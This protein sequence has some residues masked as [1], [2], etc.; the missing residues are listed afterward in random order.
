MKRALSFG[1]AISLLFA[2]FGQLVEAYSINTAQEYLEAHNDSPW[3]VMALA[4]LGAT[5]VRNDGLK[6][7]AGTTAIEY[8]APILAI[9]AMGENPR[10]FGATDY[11]AALKSY[12]HDSQLGD[13]TTLND[14]IFGILALVASDVPV[15]DAAI[16]DSKNILFTTQGLDGGWSFAIA[17]SSD[18]NMTASAILAL[19]AAEVPPTDAHILNA[20]NY[21]KSAQNDD[22]GFPY[23][24]SSSF[25]TNSDASS[26]AW[27]LWALNALGAS[28]EAWTKSGHTPEDYLT[29]TQT[30]SGY[31]EYQKGSG[32]DSFSPITTS[33]AVIALSGKKLPLKILPPSTEQQFDFRIEGSSG[34]ICS[35]TT[36]GPT[37]LDIIE[38]GS[39][40]CGYTY[41]I[42]DTSFGLYL[43]QISTDTAA[44]TK[45]WIY[46]VNNAAPSV[47]AADYT[48]KVDDHVLWFYGEYT[49]V[50]TRL[51]LTDSEAASG[52]SITVTVDS[53]ANNTWTALAN[54]TVHFGT[55]T[56]MT[57]ADGQ[58]VIHPAD[59]YYKIFAA[60]PGFVRTNTQL[61]KMGQPPSSSV[62]LNATIGQVLGDTAPLPTST[63]IAFTIEP[64]TLNFGTLTPGSS[65]AKSIAINNLGSSGIH[66]ESVVSGDELYRENLRLDTASWRSF[67]TELDKGAHRDYSVQLNVPASYA[68]GGPKSGQL[69]FWGMA[70]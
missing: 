18:T 1:V 24:P 46:L 56:A 27:V 21:L 49:L 3:S 19:L 69:T 54:T 52:S 32:E 14:D 12:H 64:T 63:T 17:S 47:G 50:P 55:E 38:H 42:A 8:A 62:S 2:P 48:L 6:T 4:T 59:G 37:A 41:H 43:D 13:P 5:S 20:I 33:Y 34:Q 25:G 40:D 70:Q 28:S 66:I 16:T 65:A 29:S 11:V 23:D 60:K 57:A 45:G 68:A 58:A 7:V 39:I 10:T 26:T 36:T 44:G 67:K 61:L 51:T 35:S 53:F 31:F 22:G 30:S 9:T 15:N